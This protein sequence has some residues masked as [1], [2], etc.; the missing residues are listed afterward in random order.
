MSPQVGRVRV[1]GD[2]DVKKARC[3]P[4]THMMGLGGSEEDLLR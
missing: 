1:E 4:R 3:E 2:A